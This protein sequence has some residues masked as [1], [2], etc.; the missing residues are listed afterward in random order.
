[1]SLYHGGIKVT[2]FLVMKKRSIFPYFAKH[3]KTQTLLKNKLWQFLSIAATNTLAVQK[4]QKTVFV[5]I[6]RRVCRQ[7]FSKQKFL[8]EKQNLI[9]FLNYFL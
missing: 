8:F 9:H 4:A 6:A 1:M 2:M 7:Y 5:Q 3:M